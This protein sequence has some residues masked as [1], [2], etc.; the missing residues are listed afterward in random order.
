[1]TRWLSQTSAADD[2]PTGI[3]M[4]VAVGLIAA[5]GPIARF[6]SPDR[7]VAYLGLNPRVHQSGEGRPRHGRITKQGRS[8]ARTMLVEAAWQA[9]RGPG[10][11]RAFFQR[12]S[13]RRGPHCGGR[14]R[15]Q[16]G[17]E[18]PVQAPKPA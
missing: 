4:V 12:L 1:M 13:A 14:R 5:T 11:L 9:V 18:I 2:D 8:H 3:D 10:P 16:A 7:L 6:A 17:G 15:T